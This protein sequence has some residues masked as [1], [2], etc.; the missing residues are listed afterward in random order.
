MNFVGNYILFL[1]I[2]ILI[3]RVMLEDLDGALETSWSVQQQ[4]QIG[5]RFQQPLCSHLEPQDW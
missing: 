3:G 1:L 5:D 4:S 2:R